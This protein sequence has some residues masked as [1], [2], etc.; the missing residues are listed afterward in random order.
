MKKKKFKPEMG[1]VYLF[2]SFKGQPKEKWKEVT[3]RSEDIYMIGD[4]PCVFV[5]EL[6]RG[7]IS[8]SHLHKKENENSK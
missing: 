6:L 1:K 7:G 2:E 8:I 3:L 5:N 4:T